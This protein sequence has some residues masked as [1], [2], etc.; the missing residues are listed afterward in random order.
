MCLVCY[1]NVSTDPPAQASLCA[2]P[3]ELSTY[4]PVCL[5]FTFAMVCGVRAEPWVGQDGAHRAVEYQD[6]LAETVCSSG[7]PCL[8]SC[9]HGIT[10]TYTTAPGLQDAL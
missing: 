6:L 5:F 8:I 1:P 2:S 3:N 7:L 9:D 10:G 4:Q